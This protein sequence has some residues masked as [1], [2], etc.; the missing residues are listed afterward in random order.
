M[1]LELGNQ[2]LE[3]KKEKNEGTFRESEAKEILMSLHFAP[4]QK[5]NITFIYIKGNHKTNN[6]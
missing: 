4:K 3:E 2:I 6:I 5:K 1:K